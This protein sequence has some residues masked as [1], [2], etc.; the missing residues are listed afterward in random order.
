MF[1]S[2]RS[3]LL[4]STLLATL[5][6]PAFAQAADPASHAATSGQSTDS[7]A[8]AAGVSSRESAPPAAE[9]STGDVVVTGTLI[10]NPNLVSSSPV[11]VI[12]QEEINLRQTNTAEQI[13]RDLPGA[14]P[15]IGSAVNN[16]NNGGVVCRSSRSGQFPQCR[17]A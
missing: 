8:P 2:C 6:S 15:S 14:V 4:T 13:L 17:A 16:G 9:T 3:R 10:R 12:G 7:A 5:A 11:A 1:T